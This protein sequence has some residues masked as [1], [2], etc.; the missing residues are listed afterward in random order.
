MRGNV[1]VM[2]VLAVVFGVAAVFL[3][4]VWLVNQEPRAALA[5]PG[6][7]AEDTVVV[8]AVPLK[9]GDR[10][11]SD[12]LKQIPW[13]AGALPTGAFHTVKDLLDAK[14]GDRQVLSAM[15]VNEPVLK[16]KVTGPGQRASLSA[17]LD[18]GMTAVSIRV[19]DVN[20]VAGFVLPGDRV[21]VLLTR[22]TNDQS[23]VDVLLQNVKVL[24]IDQTTDES[25]DHPIVG[26]AATV[27]VSTVDAQKLTLA[28]GVGQLSLALRQ[29]GAASDQ[30]T[31][32]VTLGDLTG[33]SVTTQPQTV[34]SASEP[35]V[36][37]DT[38]KVVPKAKPT[39]VQVGVLRGDQWKM[40]DVPLAP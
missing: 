26:R 38:G 17:V 35:D 15:G 18:K 19:N 1:L 16:W 32:R 7:T 30:Q 37:P 4:N 14:K 34:A 11:T 2:L 12:N 22:H 31:S 5:Q 3:S 9:F 13:T 39:S 25:K 27:E 36:K 23:Y 29:V 24:A 6:Q 40:Y 21:D 28:A 33:T 20:G 8:A 10:L